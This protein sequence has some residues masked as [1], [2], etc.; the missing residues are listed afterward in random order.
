MMEWNGME[1]M[2]WNGMD[3]MEWMEWNGMEKAGMWDDCSGDRR[4]GHLGIGRE[5]VPRCAGVLRNAEGVR[6][7]AGGRT[8]YC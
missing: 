3:G 7:V 6:G 1:W 4:G 2:E 5:L 8:I